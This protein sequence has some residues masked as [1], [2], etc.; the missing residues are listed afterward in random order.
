MNGIHRNLVVPYLRPAFYT[1][2]LLLF[3]FVA[4]LRNSWRFSLILLPVL[5]NTAVVAVSLPAPDFRYLFINT[6]FAFIAFLLGFV[7]QSPKS[8]AEV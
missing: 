3:S 2:A 8:E 1:F 4:I 7:Y 6:L 5:C